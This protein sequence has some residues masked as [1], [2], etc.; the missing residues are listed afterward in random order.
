MRCSWLLATAALSVLWLDAP[1]AAA[2]P[3]SAVDAQ[4][5]SE[6][7]PRSDGSSAVPITEGDRLS[8]PGPFGA[9]HEPDA[10]G[11]APP[12][13]AAPT[14]VPVLGPWGIAAL[15]AAMASGPA[16]VFGARS[17]RR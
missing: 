2:Q 17:R 11:S 14:P 1:P 9:V 10:L 8:M 13:P 5:A 12:P 16:L 3:T 4:S 15:I 7:V 6:G